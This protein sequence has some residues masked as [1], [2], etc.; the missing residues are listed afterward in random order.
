VQKNLKKKLIL[1]NQINP[2]AYLCPMEIIINHID[3]LEKVAEE[4]LFFAKGRKKIILYAEMGAGK[5]TF[6]KVFC[7]MMGVETE[8]SSPTFSLVNEYYFEKNNNNQVQK[9]LIRHLD[10]YRLKNLEEALDIGIEDFLYDESYVFIEWPDVILEILPE[11]IIE[12]KI[13]MLSPSSR[14]F[15]FS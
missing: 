13:E 9:G 1:I 2:F 15:I 5:T 4:L 11:D 7:K 6:T 14:K 10:L 3:E 12:I 8:T